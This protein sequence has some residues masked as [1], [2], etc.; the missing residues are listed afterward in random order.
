MYSTPAPGSSRPSGRVSCGTTVGPGPGAVPSVLHT[1]WSLR[2]Q[3]SS[4]RTSNGSSIDWPRYVD[5]R[6]GRD[7]AVDPVERPRHVV[8][9]RARDL[10]RRARE[11]DLAVRVPGEDRS[12]G[13][14]GDGNGHARRGEAQEQ[15]QRRRAECEHDEQ[16]RRAS[17]RQRPSAGSDGEP[18][19]VEE[20]R[21]VDV[22]RRHGHEQRGRGPSPRGAGSAPAAGARASA[23]S[24][25]RGAAR[26]R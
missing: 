15:Q 5:L 17:R 12:G 16:R 8:E 21:D 4:C 1:C 18:G 9:L 10:V 20:D 25:R 7:R 23:P 6:A 19:R 26:R 14:R 22:V 24:R 13:D 11:A 2:F 3:N